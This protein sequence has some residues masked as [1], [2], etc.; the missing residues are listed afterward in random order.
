MKWM[1]HFY[2]NVYFHFNSISYLYLCFREYLFL[3]D[4]ALVSVHLYC[5][6]QKGSTHCGVIPFLASNKYIIQPDEYLPLSYHEAAQ[7][8]VLGEHE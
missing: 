3:A 5:S 2:F 1:G 8:S 4:S 7:Q 6:P